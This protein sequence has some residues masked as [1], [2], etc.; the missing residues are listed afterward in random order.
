MEE[1]EK[2]ERLS[3]AGDGGRKENRGD[4]EENDSERETEQ[5]L[6]E[7]QTVSSYVPSSST[8]KTPTEDLLLGLKGTKKSKIPVPQ[9]VYIN[10][11]RCT[12]LADLSEQ[13][14]K[15][16]EK[17]KQEEEKKKP[18]LKEQKSKEGKVY[19]RLPDDDFSD[20]FEGG[21][22]SSDDSF[23]FG[24]L[25][26]DLH[27]EGEREPR[28]RKKKLKRQTGSDQFELLGFSD[29][30]DEDGQRKRDTSAGEASGGEDKAKKDFARFP[31]KRG[32]K[33]LEKAKTVGS[34]GD[35]VLKAFLGG[36]K[37]DGDG[38]EEGDKKE[39]VHEVRQYASTYYRL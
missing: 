17:W 9:S 18:Q 11:G 34:V 28:P 25:P 21:S 27:V 16:Q 36:A 14:Y 22:Y 29:D 20:S 15:Q 37:K 8:S 12:Y 6:S 3:N 13:V 32:E 1:D 10:S 38:K 26:G 23:E 30:E 2:R 5:L 39:D 33:K 24:P 4:Y 35:L 19:D 7:D 31:E